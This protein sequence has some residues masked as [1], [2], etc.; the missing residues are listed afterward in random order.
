MNWKKPLIYWFPMVLLGMA[1]GFFRQ[2]VLNNYLDETAARQLSTLTLILL[3]TVYVY[4]IY[5]SL[6]IRS[7]AQALWTG[8]LWMFL[9]FLFE[10][11]LG[12]FVS[13][14]SMSQ[15]MREY[16]ILEGRL[17]ILVLLSLTCLPY[18]YFRSKH[19]R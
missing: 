6:N 9:T 12:F 14:L 16:D 3:L 5:N 17:W 13:G 1:N 19:R 10:T 11:L 4:L 8:V 15:I 7:E 18:I 2:F